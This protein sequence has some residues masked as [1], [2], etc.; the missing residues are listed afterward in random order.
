VPG[1]GLRGDGPLRPAAATRGLGASDAAALALGDE[2][3]ALLDLA[4]DA[5]ALHDLAEARYEMFRG[6]PV[7]KVY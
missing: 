5:V 1:A 3:P 6:L 7:T 4:Q 2:V